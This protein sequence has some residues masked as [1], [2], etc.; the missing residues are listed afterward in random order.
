MSQDTYFI[1]GKRGMGKSISLE[2][3][4]IVCMYCDYIAHGIIDLG[5]HLCEEHPMITIW[6]SPNFESEFKKIE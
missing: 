6:N 4:D 2:I 1:E 3:S 5:R